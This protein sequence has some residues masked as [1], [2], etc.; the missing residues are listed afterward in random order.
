MPSQWGLVH[1]KASKEPDRSRVQ[2]DRNG[3]LGMA[4]QAK[5]NSEIS[6]LSL[7]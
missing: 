6:D 1:P 3:K 4:T 5:P 2:E 7:E